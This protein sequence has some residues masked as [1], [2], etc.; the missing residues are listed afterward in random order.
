MFVIGCLYCYIFYH[1]RVFW[2]SYEYWGHSSIVWSSSG[3]SESLAETHSLHLLLFFALCSTTAFVVH[4]QVM[5]WEHDSDCWLRWDTEKCWCGANEFQLLYHCNSTFFPL[6]GPDRKLL[7]FKASKFINFRP[8]L[9][10]WICVGRFHH[11]A[12]L[13]SIRE[14]TSVMLLLV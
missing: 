4:H 9:G 2:P 12:I 8:S 14:W 3:W 11:F 6:L 5:Q 10:H 13:E 7:Q 1:Q